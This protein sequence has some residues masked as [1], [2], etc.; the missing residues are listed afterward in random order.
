[1]ALEEIPNKSL[2]D[3]FSVEMKKK[4]KDWSTTESE[5]C[6]VFNKFPDIFILAFKIGV[7]S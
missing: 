4:L 3:N 5:V 7:N 2:D 6:G 1:M